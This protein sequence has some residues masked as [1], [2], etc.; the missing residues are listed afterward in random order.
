MIVNPIANAVVK[1]RGETVAEQLVGALTKTGPDRDELVSA[2]R[3][4]QSLRKTGGT[5]LRA[6]LIRALAGT[7]AATVPARD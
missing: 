6:E 2:I 4:A 3:A 5:T 7:E 1:G